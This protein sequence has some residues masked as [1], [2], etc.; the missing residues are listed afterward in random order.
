MWYFCRGS[1]AVRQDDRRGDPEVTR[2]GSGSGRRTGRLG[3][4]SSPFLVV[5]PLLRSVVASD[6]AECLVLRF[7]ARSS[8][9]RCSRCL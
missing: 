7:P 1:P 2:E 8:A 3:R 5:M 6:K 4:G 9:Q